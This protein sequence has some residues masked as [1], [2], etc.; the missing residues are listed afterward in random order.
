MFSCAGMDLVV[1]C[2]EVNMCLRLMG[3]DM[4]ALSTVPWSLP[5]Q[6]M[7]PRSG[8]DVVEPPLSLPALSFT[9][10]LESAVDD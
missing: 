5:I 10:T 4:E 8:V 1:F 9:A 7:V 6:L 2:D 3:G